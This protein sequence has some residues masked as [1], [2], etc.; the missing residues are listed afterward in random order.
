MIYN[1]F[2]PKI[3]LVPELKASW[4]G[5]IVSENTPTKLPVK[6]DDQKCFL[7]I[8]HNGKKNWC[9][10]V[11]PFRKDWTEIDLGEFSQLN[12]SCNILNIQYIKLSLVDKDENESLVH[13]IPKDKFL[14]EQ[15]IALSFDNAVKE[16]LNTEQDFVFKIDL[17]NF[18][19]K[20]NDFDLINARLLK[21][22]FAERSDLS[23]FNI[24]LS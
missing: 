11:L 7:P 17:S 22:I 13:L 21:F 3:C 4:A 15:G 19:D 1:I 14:K 6:S 8:T 16:E 2:N 10:A 9:A 12:F 23:L 24:F 18:Y 20:N 5:N